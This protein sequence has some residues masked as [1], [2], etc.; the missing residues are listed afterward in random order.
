MIATA[1][2]EPAR[3]ADLAPVLDLLAAASL[4]REGVGEHFAGF[5]VAR[6]GGEVVGAVGQERYGD[7]VLLRSLVVAPTHRG[8]GLGQ[9]LV[10]GLLAEARR[11]GA[12]RVFL[13]TET[14]ADFFAGLGFAR[15]TRAEAEPAVGASLELTHGMSAVRGLHVPGAR[16]RPA[17]SR[18]TPCRGVC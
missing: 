10:A 2:V 11:S 1:S 14:A 9:A 18:L 12:R 6:A 4:P 8:R 5:L 15:T 17:P 13:L 16:R 7:A 3:A